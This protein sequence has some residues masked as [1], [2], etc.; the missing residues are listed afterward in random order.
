MKYEI[1]VNGES[2]ELF[3]DTEHFRYQR[4]NGD[5]VEHAYSLVE[6]GD[7]AYSVLFGGRS[8]SARSLGGDEFSVNGRV[9]RVEVF[10]PRSRRAV[11]RAAARS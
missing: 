7:R 8:Y 3:A 2:A 9:F 4:S 6:A 11:S 10:D 1:L 5:V